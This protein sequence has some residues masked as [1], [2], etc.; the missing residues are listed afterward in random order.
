[1]AAV[2]FAAFVVGGA[3]GWAIGHATADGRPGQHQF[4]NRGPGPNGGDGYGHHRSG[5]GQRPNG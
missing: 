1:M 4:Q 5:T 3:G 2:V